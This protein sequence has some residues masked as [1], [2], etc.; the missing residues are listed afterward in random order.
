MKRDIQWIPP[1]IIAVAI[2]PMLFIV[3]AAGTTILGLIDQFDFLEVAGIMADVSLFTFTAMLA[4]TP[5]NILFGWRWPLTLRRPLGLIAFMY[6][7]VHYLVFMAGFQFDIGAGLAATAASN[8][9]LFG[10]F[11]VLFM[12]PLALTS[13][14]WSMNKLGQNWKRLHALV[15][16]I[17]IFIVLHMLLLG[18]GSL[19]VPTYLLL[20]GVRIPSIRRAIVRWRRNRINNHLEPAPTQTHRTVVEGGAI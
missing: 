1:T 5:L 6:S 10:F 7:A 17:A 11:G 4:C 19:T 15:Y 16:A 18:Q 20:L 13:N 14:R 9:L 8:M 2:L 3:G 12:V